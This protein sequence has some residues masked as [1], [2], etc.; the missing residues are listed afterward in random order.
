MTWT[1][2]ADPEVLSR[3]KKNRRLILNPTMHGGQVAYNNV[4]LI[5]QIYRGRVDRV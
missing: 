4:S 1:S 2:I 3:S 5:S